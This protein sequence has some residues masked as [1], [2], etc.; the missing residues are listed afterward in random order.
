MNHFFKKK[1]KLRINKEKLFSKDKFKMP[2][3][4]GNTKKKKTFALTKKGLKLKF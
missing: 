3:S 1:A 4:L 2:L